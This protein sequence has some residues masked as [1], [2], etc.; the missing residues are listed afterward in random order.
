MPGMTREVCFE[1]LGI[2]VDASDGEVKKAYKK[3]ALKWHPDKNPSNRE[4]ANK[5]FLRISEAYKRI[6]DPDSFKDE[7][8]DGEMPSEE[9]M[10]SMFNMMFSE[11]MGGMFGGGGPMG[12]G[13][14][15][16]MAEMMAAEMMGGMGGGGAFS[17]SDMMGAI[18]S[19]D[20][21]DEEEAFMRHMMMGGMGP[22]GPSMPGGPGMMEQMFMSGMMEDMME[23]GMEEA[24]FAALGGDVG[25]GRRGMHGASRH[26]VN[27]VPKNT[28]RGVSKKHPT[29][30]RNQQQH[31][32]NDDDVWETESDEQYDEDEDDDPNADEF[33]FS[34]LRNGMPPQKAQTKSLN[35][36][37]STEKET[38]RDIDLRAL[39]A[40]AEMYKHMQ[41]MGGFATAGQLGELDQDMMDMLGKAYGPDAS[42]SSDSDDSQIDEEI[43]NDPLLGGMYES[44]WGSSSKS[45][46]GAKENRTQA[47]WGDA[48]K[49]GGGVNN[50]K[51]K[52]NN[53]SAGKE[54]R[55]GDTVKVADGELATV[56][57][58]GPVH[59]AKGD[60]AGIIMNNPAK[61][62]NDGSVKG[63]R[64]FTTTKGRGLMV[65]LRD[66]TKVIR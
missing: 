3:L 9:E 8:D 65:K 10:A 17:M 2:K 20:E 34:Y 24:M 16:M 62:K 14:G 54:I 61:G 27:V 28:R 39:K 1:T 64:Y 58:I 52:V 38:Q 63:E 25:G 48:S 7:D 46:S 6:T 23:G 57:F 40:E 13:M 45:S 50:T 5:Q 47:A 59:Y 15:G 32:P 51:S 55:V 42:D 60:F 21:E 33:D 30:K 26:K 49:G 36:K 19:D 66:V 37:K 11:M 31:V 22:G 44:Q 56:A 18:D 41:T 43:L 53:S 12:G 29:T 35:S 4:E